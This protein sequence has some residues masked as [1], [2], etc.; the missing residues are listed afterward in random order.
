MHPLGFNRIQPRT[1]A[2][3]AANDQPATTV[4]LDSAV[5]GFDPLAH[6]LAVVPRRIVPDHEQ[7]ALT[8]CAQVSQEPCQ[9]STGD[10][11]DWTPRH[12]AHQPLCKCREIKS[13]T[14]HCFGFAIR[15]RNFLF[16]QSQRLVFTPCMKC[17]LFLTT[18]PSFIGKAQCNV[19]R[20]LS[21]ANQPVTLFFLTRTADQG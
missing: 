20:V 6:N 16:H 7:G 21:Q 5:I 14:G 11:A 18:P 10:T 8:L 19:G 12:K 9:E 15:S 17:W 4:S 3:Q 2:G 13:I 1:L